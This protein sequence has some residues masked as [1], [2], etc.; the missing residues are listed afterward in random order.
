MN[1]YSL[2]RVLSERDAD[3]SLDIELLQRGARFAYSLHPRRHYRGVFRI[4]VTNR[5]V[6]SGSGNIRRRSR[7]GNG[8]VGSPYS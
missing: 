1:H 4:P 5:G 6:S 7:G 2:W 8:E 3:A